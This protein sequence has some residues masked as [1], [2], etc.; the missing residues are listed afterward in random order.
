MDSPGLPVI[1]DLVGSS[2]DDDDDVDDD[3]NDCIE[4]LNSRF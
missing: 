2:V 1:K 4:R 3:H